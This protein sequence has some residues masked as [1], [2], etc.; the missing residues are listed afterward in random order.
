MA[1]PLGVTEAGPALDPALVGYES[2]GRGIP[3]PGVL[4][5]NVPWGV[6]ASVACD[7]VNT[8]VEDHRPWGVAEVTAGASA[9][10]SVVVGGG[11]VVVPPP[12]QHQPAA[13][14]DNASV[15]QY[16]SPTTGLFLQVPL[17]G[18]LYPTIKLIVIN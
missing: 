1:C 13:S 7:V 4:G 17:V 14:T 11:A 12:R 10:A 18:Q 2:V 9:V 16:F 5:E 6:E 15:S 8:V 3:A